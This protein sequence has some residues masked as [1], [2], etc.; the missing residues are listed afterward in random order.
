MTRFASIALL[1]LAAAL[2]PSPAVTSA[3]A[4]SPTARPPLVGE[5]APDFTLADQ[6]GKPVRLSAARG[7]KAVL[8]FYRGYW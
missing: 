2:P 4:A 8:V 1:A 7:E 5:A 3:L 6:N